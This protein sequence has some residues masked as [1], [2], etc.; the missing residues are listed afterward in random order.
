MHSE[1]NNK[2]QRW[3]RGDSVLYYIAIDDF[4][5]RKASAI[6]QVRMCQ[7]F[8]RAGETVC[9]IHPGSG[10]RERV[11]WTELAES[12]GLETEF[13]V[14]TVP[15]LEEWSETVPQ[16]GPLSEMATVTATVAT[17]AIKGM[18]NS[19]DIVYGRNYY[20]LFMLNE[21]RKLLPDSRQPTVAFEHH[22]RKSA[23]MKQRFF[24]SIDACIATSETL[25]KRN[26]RAFDL[27]PR[28]C[29]VASH[30]VELSRYASLD[31]TTAREQLGLSQDHP[32]V[33]YT[34]QL[35]PRKGAETLVRAAPDIDAEVYIIGGPQESIDRIRQTVGTPANVTFT[36]FVHPT[37]IPQYQVAADVLVA[38]YTNADLDLNTP[39]KII[40]YLAAGRPIVVSDKPVLHSILSAEETALYCTPE[41]V[42]SLTASVQRILAD[43][44]L[45]SKLGANA[46]ETAQQY[47]YESRAERILSHVRNQ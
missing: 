42:E 43:E 6:Q 5:R 18:L 23:R 11:R 19:S 28:R 30:G 16:I 15:T 40:E 29:L 2:P 31:R 22:D 25:K 24:R 21:L 8:E 12:Y 7:A 4:S 27:D 39:V 33:A 1:G 14:R 47:S 32:I 44:T 26:C 41:S 36:G 20:G 46:A 3:R 10:F 45:A 9:L 13:E 17:K 38:P 35:Y 37:S 34:G